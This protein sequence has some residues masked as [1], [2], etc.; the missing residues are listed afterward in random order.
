MLNEGFFWH[1]GQAICQN[2]A[3]VLKPKKKKMRTNTTQYFILTIPNVDLEPFLYFLTLNCLP[4]E[5]EDKWRS[6]PGTFQLSLCMPVD[7]D[8][9]LLTR[10]W[11]EWKDQN[12]ETDYAILN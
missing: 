3:I 8:P 9:S 6:G 7:F 11:F 5:L 2:N 1:D 10:M 4:V 12:M